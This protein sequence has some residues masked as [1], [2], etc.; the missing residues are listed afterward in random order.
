MALSIAHDES[1]TPDAVTGALPYQIV[2]LLG[3]GPH[4]VTYLAQTVAGAR[5]YVA[6]KILR[7]RTDV[8][9]TLSR[10]RHLRPVLEGLR[11]P[12]LVSVVDAGQAGPNQ[13]YI[14]SEYVAGTPLASFIARPAA[15]H[16]VRVAIAHQV[17]AGVAA[18]HARGIA[19]AKLDRTRVKITDAD[20][21]MAIV[22]GFGT[23]LIVDGP[24][25]VDV[26]LPALAQ[27]VRD[28]G[29]PLGDQA[30][31]SADAIRDVLRTLA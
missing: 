10:Y 30:Y 6:L 26:D 2:T 14:A 12:N 1:P 13:I 27:I 28:L 22:L 7:A 4:D 31:P 29:I 18:A 21:V 19:H 25:S 9:D 20:G 16:A 15:T 23:S 8:S 5:R 17:A 24:R 11:H 3:G